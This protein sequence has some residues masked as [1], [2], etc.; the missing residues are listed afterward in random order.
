VTL[1]ATAA[2]AFR[3]SPVVAAT[4][5]T[6]LIHPF[7]A[8]QAG[9]VNGSSGFDFGSVNCESNSP[10]I[11]PEHVL[12][13]N[14]GTYNSSDVSNRTSG[15]QN[16]N[17]FF[18]AQSSYQDSH[19]DT[20]TCGPYP[21]TISIQGSYTITCVNNGVLDLSLGVCNCTANYTG[22]TCAYQGPCNPSAGPGAC[23]LANG[24]TG[25]RNCTV[26]S[27]NTTAW[28]N[29]Q[30]LPT[31]TT[32]TKTTSTTSATERASFPAFQ[33]GFYIVYL[34]LL[35]LLRLA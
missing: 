31:T 34:V 29:C 11:T 26:A 23:A 16:F 22:D 35:V 30:A 2:L 33:T 27:N 8:Q 1:S 28:G 14:T 12:F 25:T 18:V 19:Q 24:V 9:C 17:F 6:I 10:S 3:L 5:V 13:S 7:Y 20:V 15:A 4:Y 21:I 32:T